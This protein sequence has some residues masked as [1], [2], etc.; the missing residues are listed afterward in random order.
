[1]QKDKILKKIIVLCFFIFYNFNSFGLAVPSLSGPVV[2][3][4]GIL[5]RNEFNKIEN[6]LLDLNN[7]SQIQIAVLIVPSLEGESIEDYSMQVAEKW[8]LGDKEKD[9]GALLLVAV[10]DK[11]LRIEVGYGLEQNLT[12]SR[13][14]QIIRNFIAPQFRSGNYGEGIYDGIKAMAAYASEDESLLKE[15]AVSDEDDEGG[16]PHIL[17]F[18]IFAYL[19]ISKFLPGGLFWIF[20]LLSR[21][22]RA[23]STGS[24]F[25]GSIGRS[26]GRGFSGG[27]FS[28]GGG[29]FGGGGASGGW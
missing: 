14:G 2:D 12:D 23:S 26:S 11:K 15:I 17:L 9:S 7:R 6:F 5:S 4:A 20:Y 19:M 10:K 27:G 29:S 25:G 3:K 24:F 1:M 22:G 18:L 28:G 13:S 8:K 16:F 21:R